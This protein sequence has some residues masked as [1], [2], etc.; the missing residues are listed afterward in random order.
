MTHWLDNEANVAKLKIAIAG[1]IQPANQRK[2]VWSNY[3]DLIMTQD[4]WDDICQ[5]MGP[6]SYS[7]LA[8][9]WDKSGGFPDDKTVAV[10]SEVE[11]FYFGRAVED[12]V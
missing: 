10:F 5:R 12:E 3:F 6:E 8:A 11:R 4:C 7:A 2:M 1:W 9:E